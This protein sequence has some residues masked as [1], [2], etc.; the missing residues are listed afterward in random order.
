MPSLIVLTLSA[1]S[2]A[3]LSGELFQT[4]GAARPEHDPM[5][6]GRKMTGR[7]LA[8]STARASDENDFAVDVRFMLFVRFS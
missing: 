6:F 2:R 1:T 7:G 3:D 4:V 5:P 8:D